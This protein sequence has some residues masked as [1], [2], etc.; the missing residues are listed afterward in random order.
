[1]TFEDAIK[2]QEERWAAIHAEFE[3]CEKTYHNSGDVGE[4]KDS[5]AWALLRAKFVEVAVFILQHPDLEFHTSSVSKK[6]VDFYLSWADLVGWRREAFAGES[7][8][9]D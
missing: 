7:D 6:I 3:A 5:A 2:E 8:D 9:E 1:M 4:V